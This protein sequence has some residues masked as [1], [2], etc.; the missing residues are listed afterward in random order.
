MP[1]PIQPLFTLQDG[2]GYTGRMFN[3]DVKTV[4]TGKID[5]SLGPL[6]SHSFRAGMATMMAEAGCSDDQIQLAGRWSSDAFKLYV[7]TARLRRAVMAASILNCL[8]NTGAL[9]NRY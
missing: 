7:K 4:L 6:T 3:N 5:N 1:T 8:K 2:S 9:T